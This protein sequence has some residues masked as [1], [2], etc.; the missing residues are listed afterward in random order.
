MTILVTTYFADHMRHD[1][2][3]FIHPCTYMYDL[4]LRIFGTFGTFGTSNIRYFQKLFQW[5]PIG[6]YQ[7][8]ILAQCLLLSLKF[9]FWLLYP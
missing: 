4:L 2:L 6:S 3:K 7:G 9:D 5:V 1:G 8:N